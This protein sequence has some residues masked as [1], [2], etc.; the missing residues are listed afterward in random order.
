MKKLLFLIL[1]FF[2]IGCASL[3]VRNDNEFQISNMLLTREQPERFGDYKRQ[4]VFAQGEAFW[5]YTELKNVTIIYEDE[6]KEINLTGYLLIRDD[7]DQIIFAKIIIDY[8]GYIKEDVSKDE[9]Y[10]NYGLIIPESLDIGKYILMLEIID[11]HTDQT[12]DAVTILRVKKKT[13]RI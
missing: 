9:I 1:I 7:T 6:R 10:I 8:H 2:V 5:L 12:A 3:S 11:G 13:I 4:R